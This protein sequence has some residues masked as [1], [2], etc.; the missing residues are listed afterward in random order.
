MTP[1]GA[2]PPD[3]PQLSKYSVY[4]LNNNTAGTLTGEHKYKRVVNMANTKALWYLEQLDTMPL[5]RTRPVIPSR[6]VNIYERG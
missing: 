1:R 3:P 2:S 4:H 6:Q 5:S